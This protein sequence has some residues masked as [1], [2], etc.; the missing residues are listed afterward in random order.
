MNAEVYVNM[1]LKQNTLGVISCKPHPIYTLIRI[2]LQ[3]SH[4][5]Q[6]A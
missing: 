1:S 5:L 3:F 4:Q 2:H 6:I